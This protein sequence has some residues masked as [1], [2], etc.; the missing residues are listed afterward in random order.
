MRPE[1]MMEEKVTASVEQYTHVGLLIELYRDHIKAAYGLSKKM[2]EIGIERPWVTVD[3]PVE[4]G[5]PSEA[6]KFIHM[7]KTRIRLE[8]R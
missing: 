7:C 6:T 2:K 1:N 3:E 8:I 4:V 5:G